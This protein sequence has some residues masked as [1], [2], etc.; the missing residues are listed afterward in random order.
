M[1]MKNAKLGT[2][3]YLGFGT[4]L[5]FLGMIL[6]VSIT[7]ILSIN[8]KTDKIVHDYNVKLALANSMIDEI[9]VVARAVRNIVLLDDPTEMALEKKRI[10]DA[11][12]RFET[13]F[14]KL[15]QMVSSEKGIEL[16]RTIRSRQDSVKPITNKV[17]SL[18]LEGKRDEATS[19]LVKELRVPQR[20]FIQTIS[21]L[22][23]YQNELSQKAAKEAELQTTRSIWSISV[24]GIAAVLIGIAAAFFTTKNVTRQLH[25]IIDGLNDSAEQVVSVSTQI[26]SGS[27]SLA[28]GSQQQAAALE[29]TSAAI[30]QITSMTKRNAQN[31]EQAD[32]LMREAEQVMGLAESSMK[33]LTQSMQDICKESE[34]TFKIVK[35]IDEIAFQT[36]LLALNAAVEAARAGEAGAGFAVVADEVRN[37]AKRAAEAAKN[38]ASLIEATVK[39][40]QEGA[41]LASQS[42]QAFDKMTSTASNVAQLVAEIA[43]ASREQAQGIGEMN[44][45][46]AEMEKVVQQNAAN[47]EENAASSEEMNGQANQMEGF[48]QSLVAIVGTNGNGKRYTPVLQKEVMAYKGNVLKR[49]KLEALKPAKNGKRAIGTREV[50][51]PLDAKEEALIAHV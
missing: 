3:L 49:P 51:I 26:A 4:V 28:E 13:S 20:T 29:E 35:S 17:I 9:N 48:V 31:A 10:E 42:N 16:L 18:G 45:A 36:N 50:L 8:K 14:S 19:V 38:T 21:D 30:E 37:L 46:I 39:N 27:Q 23:D 15:T 24:L 22:I 1:F 32:Q 43:A 40:I 5:I 47:A 44:R 11:R 41:K 7:N 25:G 2:K 12:S 6:A 33:H 34:E